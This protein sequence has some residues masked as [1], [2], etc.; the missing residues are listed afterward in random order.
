[1]PAVRHIDLGIVDFKEAWDYQER[2]LKEIVEVKIANRD[3]ASNSPPLNYLLTCEHSHVFT[4]GKSGDVSNLL[5]NNQEL[6]DL[7]AKFYKINRGGDMTYH[8]PGQLVVYPIFDLE[9]FFTDIHKYMRF[10]EQAVIDALADF[11]IASGRIEGLTGV[12]I[13]GDHP[14]KICAFGVK[15]SRWVTMHGIGFNINTDLSYF[16]RIVPCGITDKQVTSMSRELNVHLD[17]DAVKRSLLRHLQSLFS[18]DFDN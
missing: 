4:L 6:V 7:D 1:M 11:G 16:E 14:R 12:W 17:F 13:L 15:S 3:N 5:A 9:Q 10:L 8:G 2:L 18:F